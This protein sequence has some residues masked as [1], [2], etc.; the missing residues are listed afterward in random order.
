MEV[1]GRVKG[2]GGMK[3]K[4][5]GERQMETGRVKQ[6]VREMGRLRQWGETAGEKDAATPAGVYPIR[7]L[8]PVWAT[9]CEPQ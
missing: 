5:R 7:A 9:L 1:S 4:Q 2:G 3:V 6:W 8:Q